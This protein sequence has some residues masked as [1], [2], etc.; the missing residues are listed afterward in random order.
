MEF[1]SKDLVTLFKTQSLLK[2]KPGEEFTLASGQKSKFYL[3][4]RRSCLNPY[5]SFVLGTYLCNK[6]Q[7]FER[8]SKKPIHAVAGVAL[9]GC[10]LATAVSLISCQQ[11]VNRHTYEALYV[12][13]EPKKH[14]TKSLIEG[15][16]KPGQNVVLLEDVTTTGASALKAVLTLREAGLHVPSVLS[17]VDRS[18]GEMIDFFGNHGIDFEAAVDFDSIIYGE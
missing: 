17:L 16:F 15:N 11:T 18:D 6:V 9:G 14:G 1:F 3:D 5:G 2:A 10:P 13:P 4:L 7:E 8:I 12:R